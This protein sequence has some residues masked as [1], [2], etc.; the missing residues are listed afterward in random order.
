MNKLII[1]F[2]FLISSLCLK[3]VYIPGKSLP[4]SYYVVSSSEKSTDLLKEKCIVKGYVYDALTGEVL[5]GTLVSDLAKNNKDLTDSTGYYEIELNSND[6]SIF[7]FKTFKKEL[8]V[9]SI[10]FEE[11]MI[12]HINFFL[13][14]DYEQTEMDKP[15]IYMYSEQELQTSVHIRPNGDLTFTYPKYDIE[16]GWTAMVSN[17]GIMVENQHYPYLFWE[18]ATNNLNYQ[19]KDNAIY[20]SFI[21]TDTCVRFLENSLKMMGL[22][23]TETTDFIT[24]WAPRLL[25][26]NYAFIQFIED[27][28]YQNAVCEMSIQ[29]QPDSQKRI[30]MLFTL[31]S[32][33]QG[34]N[35]SP[36]KFSSF[37][38]RGF[39]VVEWGGS[40][41]KN[42]P[43]YNYETVS[44]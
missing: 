41:L 16:T 33:Y 40:E 21:S 39:T 44:K 24:F 32:E 15:V 38:R 34:A 9:W 22:N 42:C 11:G 28:S 6:T 36:Q 31:Y 5:A 12:Y 37:Q 18:G 43:L 1:L 26:N 29:P 14:E 30:Y 20:G 25:Q 23:S 17:L 2:A 3:A 27:E 4:T 7:A 35:Y 10:H 8:I 19:E 13:S